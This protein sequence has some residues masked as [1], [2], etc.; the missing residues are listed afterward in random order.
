LW[1][2][3][4]DAAILFIRETVIAKPAHCFEQWV[5]A[6]AIL[7]IR[8]TVIANPDEKLCVQAIGMRQSY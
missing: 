5:Q 1:A 3:H 6:A 2:G 7:F 8:E 4:R